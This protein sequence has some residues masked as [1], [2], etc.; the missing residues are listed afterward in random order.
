[1]LKLRFCFGIRD[2]AVQHRHERE[3]ESLR[4]NSEITQSEIAFV[5]LPIRDS[6]LDQFIDELLDFL[7][8]RLGKT[9]RRA[10][11]DVGQAND[12]ALLRLR[13]WPGITKALFARPLEYPPR[14]YS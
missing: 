10:F 7:R 13:F 4:D 9:A 14:A 8:G 3:A 12:R 6:F 11:H 5:K 2:A 1:M